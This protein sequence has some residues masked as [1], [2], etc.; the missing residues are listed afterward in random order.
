[1]AIDMKRIS[2]PNSSKQS[3]ELSF[4]FNL[5]SAWTHSPIQAKDR[6]FFTE[7][8]ALMLETGNNLYASLVALAKQMKNPAFA[9]LIDSLQGDVSAGKTFAFALGKF[10]DVFSVS[11]VNLIAASEQGGFMHKALESLVRMEQQS[12]ELRST[13]KSALTYPSFLMV[14]SLSVVIFVLTVVFP[15]FEGMFSSIEDQLPA[16][17]AALMWMSHLMIDYWWLLLGG[18]VALV[19]ALIAWRSTPSGGHTIDRWKLNI[20]L[21]KDVFIKIYCIQIFQVLSLSLANG[22]TLVDAAKA[23]ETVVK[24]VVFV[25]FIR[26]L[27]QNVTE[28]KSFAL[29][30]QQAEFIPPIV[31]QMIE[32]GEQTGNLALVLDR[33]TVYF[34]RELTQGL[35]LF[36]RLIEPIM[37]IVMG[38]VV[39][40]LVSSIILPIFKLSSA[41]H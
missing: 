1:M 15:K 28:G 16:T 22:V 10:P 31:E 5:D 26:G 4:S 27:R 11:Y 23:S 21:L 14:F 35:A 41:A 13:L 34:R 29:G 8:L 25:D 32:T 3:R 20:P 24:N 7:Q 33:I 40:L 37:L 19:G 2:N 38:V 30:F 18:A 12:D 39:G 36:S 9:K 6:I 17:T